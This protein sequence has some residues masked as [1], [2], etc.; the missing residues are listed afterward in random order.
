MG[1]HVDWD[2]GDRAPARTIIYWTF[3][4]LWDWGEFSAADEK[5]YQMALSV[6]HQVDSLVDFTRSNHLPMSGAMT[7]FMRSVRRNPPNRG[8]VVVF[9]ANSVIRAIA[10][11][12]KRLNPAFAEN[13]VFADNLEDAYMLLDKRNQRAGTPESG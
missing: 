6:D 13:Y 8:T 9:A 4:G 1:V 7:Y 10:N 2:T 5:A 12:L 3:E 11:V